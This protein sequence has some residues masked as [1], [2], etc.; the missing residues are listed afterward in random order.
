MHNSIAKTLQ[1][2]WHFTSLECPTI[3]D[4]SK[5]IHDP[6]FKGGVIT[7][8]YKQTI[9]PLLDGLDQQ[10]ESIGAVNNVYLSADGKLRG[11]N[12]DWEGVKGCLLSVPGSEAGRRKPALV[13]GAGGASRAAVYALS[14]DLGC[15]KI[16]VI[17]RDESE[18]LALK[19]DAIKHSGDI[20]EVVH[21]TSVKQAGK[22]ESPYF[23]V[24]TVPDL[25]AK[26][27]S[28]ILMKEILEAFLRAENKG[29]LLDMCFKPRKTRMLKL[30]KSLGWAC[31]EGINVIGYQIYTQWSV[32]MGKDV[33]SILNEQEAWRVLNKA[34]EE[35]T[36]INS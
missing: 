4:V 30:A 17:N 18:V 31:V 26:T 13:I 8:P 10:A 27:E 15:K 22:L 29:V 16:Y 24:G 3:D 20:L 25:E 6:A 34:A 21:V 7:M 9:I 12:T 5:A 36:A 11:T 35:S 14:V 23:V 28:E 32:W 1:V 33:S 2:P 19:K